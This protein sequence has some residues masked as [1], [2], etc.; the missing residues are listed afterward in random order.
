MCL[1]EKGKIVAGPDQTSFLIASRIL[2]IALVV[3]AWPLSLKTTSL[4]RDMHEAE[5]MLREGSLDSLEWEFLQ[6]YYVEPINVPR[7]EL[8][9]L[10]DA[11]DVRVENLPVS[12]EQLA[13]YRPWD[14]A[15]KER[16]FRDYPELAKYEPILSFSEGDGRRMSNAGLALSVG[17]DLTTAASS[18]FCLRFAP[19][20]A[21]T[22]SISHSDTTALW[23]KRSVTA[24]MPGIVS[25][26]A[27]NFS[28]AADHGLFYGY[29]PDAPAAP[30]T[31][32]SNWEYAGS[33]AWNGLYLRSARWSKTQVSAFFHER[34]T[35]RAFGIFCDAD[36]A[37]ALRVS[38]GV[39]R[40][41][42]GPADT[43][44]LADDYFI[45]YGVSGTAAGFVYRINAGTARSSPLSMPVEAQCSRRARDGAAFSVLVA[46]L[47]AG[48]ALARSKIA[49]DCRNELDLSDSA[50]AS[51]I[52]LADCR[53]SLALSEAFATSASLSFV[54]SGSRAALTAGAGVAGKWLVNYRLSYD[55]RMS[56]ALS[57]ETHKAQIVVERALSRSVKPE[58][59]C[60][61]YLR[62]DGFGSVNA[63]IP[64]AVSVPGG[65]TIV[66][67][68]AAYANTL[69]T[70]SYTGGLKQE[71][72]ITGETWCD[73]DASTSLDENNKQEW[74]VN[75]RANF[76]F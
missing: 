21:V 64:V 49:F 1:T 14:Q 74:N 42:R 60:N 48:S 25:L 37:E 26:D 57:Q 65:M 58:L 55:Y 3:S 8:S 38:A 75:A 46:R 40:L 6:P 45:H 24:T 62:D 11:F 73:C 10:Y 2:I 71:F 50:S 5:I 33:H 76:C 18:R 69:R 29:F 66:P 52:T 54:T 72:H 22:G 16:F 51:D 68:V 12:R 19:G 17:N 31:T 30:V 7:G 67:Y 15:A 61:V 9:L 63:R 35:E 32:L 36:V 43:G 70:R 56:T 59:S 41:D 13:A 27:G 39:S 28:L 23:V 53:T 44:R 34:P 20:V 47:P 4:P